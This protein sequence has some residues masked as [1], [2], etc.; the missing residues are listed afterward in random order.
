[1]ENTR[2]KT[3]LLKQRPSYFTYVSALDGL[4]ALGVLLVLGYHFGINGFKGGFLGVNLFF[5]LSGFLM[6]KTSQ[7]EALKQQFSLGRFYIKRIKRIYPAMIMM[8]LMSTVIATI[9]MRSRLQSIKDQ[10]LSTLIGYNNWWQINHSVSYFDQLNQQ[11]PFTHMWSLGVELNFYLIWPIIFMIGYYLINSKMKRVFFGTLAGAALLYYLSFVFTTL[12]FS[13]I[14]YGTDTRIFSFLF[15]T[16]LASYD[17]E[18]DILG[19]RYSDQSKLIKALIQLIVLGLSV[20]CVTTADGQSA[21]TYRFTMVLFTFL[22][23]GLIQLIV[24]PTIWQKL[25]NFP[26][27]VWL[28]KRSYGI[29]I[30]HYPVIF[31]C[32]RLLHLNNQWLLIGIELVITLLI[33]EISYGFLEQPILHFKLNEP[34]MEQRRF[35][36]PMGVLLASLIVIT[37]FGLLTTSKPTE[38]PYHLASALHKNQH[39]LR[40]QDKSDLIIK[41]AQSKAGNPADRPT[42]SIGDSVMLGASPALKQVF[43]HNYVDAVESRQAFVLPTLLEKYKK[44]NQ[45]PNQ[46]LVGLGTNG[47]ITDKTVAETFKIVGKKRTVYWLNMYAPTIQW[48]NSINQE[49]KAFSKKYDNLVI[50]DW[51]SEGQKHPEWFYS[52]EIHLNGDGQSGYAKFIRDSIK[53]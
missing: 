30:Y 34:L 27:L 13:R 44:Q 41:N 25:F 35:N 49:L 19:Y 33:T 7:N 53:G 36:K 14:Y 40:E 17:R 46:I 16:W 43:K 51:H 23:V 47:Y 32:T 22:T 1:M 3:K 28:G 42:L 20:W 5:A 52:D 45:L 10:F 6:M 12:D 48:S 4:R 39:Q 50:I 37:A 26:L 29:Y 15:G 18:I 2:N 21:V 31:F 8:V 38:A 9:F 24:T 11:S